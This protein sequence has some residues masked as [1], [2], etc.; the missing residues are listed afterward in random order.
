MLLAAVAP[1]TDKTQAL[2][3]A[4]SA[5]RHAEE[6]GYHRIWYAEHHDARSFASQA[7]EILIA[8]A[9]RSPQHPAHPSRLRSGTAQP[10]QPL[11]ASPFQLRVMAG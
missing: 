3:D 10:L 6:L 11:L 5:A 4:V 7:P 2:H 1:G 9:A 8:V